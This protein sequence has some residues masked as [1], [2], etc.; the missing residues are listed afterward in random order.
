MYYGN[1]YSKNLDAK[2]RYKVDIY[3]LDFIKIVSD[4]FH[5]LFK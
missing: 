3:S 5:P 4:G 2:P 1:I